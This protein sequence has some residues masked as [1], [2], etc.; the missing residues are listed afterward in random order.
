[1]K[2]QLTALKAAFPLT[3]P[4]MLGYLFVGIAF[5]VLLQQK[6]YGPPWAALMSVCVYAGSMQFVAI[7]FFAPGVSLVTVAFVTFVVNFRHIF[8]GLSFLKPFDRAGAKKPYLIFALT[9]ETYSLLCGTKIPAGVDEGWFFFSISLLNQLYWIIGSV[10]GAAA[11][12][13]IPFNTTGIDFAMTALFVV[14]AVEQWKASSTHIPALLGAGV[15]VVCLLVFGAANFVLP[16][17][18]LIAA[19]LVGAR[20]PIEPRLAVDAASSEDIG[21][22]LN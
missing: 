18:V 7:Q 1:M 12:A 9:D 2:K 11:G 19:A 13:L 17:A 5:G 6:G 22:V 10:L 20:K 16:A 4:V 14:I 21:D 3:V 8:Y 15:A